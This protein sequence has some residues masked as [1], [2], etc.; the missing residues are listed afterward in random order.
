MSPVRVSRIFVHPLKSCRGISV[1]HA[2]FT[3]EGLEFDRMW[4]LMG[5]DGTIITAREAPK[6]ILITTEILEDA[7]QPHDGVLSVTFPSDSHC[8]AFKL[9]LRPT[10][11]LLAKWEHVA[12]VSMDELPFGDGYVCKA[13]SGSRSPSAILSDYLEQPVQLVYKGP[14]IRTCEPTSTYANAAPAVFQ[15]CYP[16]MVL[17][18]ESTKAIEEETQNHIGKQGV[19]ERWRTDSIV[20]QRFRPNIVFEGAGPFAE[21]N[22]NKVRIGGGPE[23][24]LVSKCLRCLLPNVSPD[25]GVRDAAV[26]F[27]VIMKFRRVDAEHKMKPCVGVNA[28]PQGEGI[29]RVGDVVEWE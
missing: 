8:E 6:M 5:P 2:R 22:W 27:K 7:S 29:V 16:V 19:E 11:E 28:V 17:S 13:I 18:E 23:I 1:D 15:D 26:P 9:P 10:Q 3:P 12:K 21:D 20:I 24:T 14:Q 4:C 25:T